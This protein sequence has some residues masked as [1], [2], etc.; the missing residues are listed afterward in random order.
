MMKSIITVTSYILVLSGLQAFP[1][2]PSLLGR[3][4]FNEADGIVCFD[5]STYGNN[6]E[7]VGAER[8]DGIHGSALRFN[9]GNYALTPVNLPTPEKGFSLQLWVKP[10]AEATG[11][12]YLA[13]ESGRFYLRMTENR[14]IVF[15]VTGLDPHQKP[16]ELSAMT[17]TSLPWNEWS[18]VSAVFD[19]T[20]AVAGINGQW[21]GRSSLAATSLHFPAPKPFAPLVLGTCGWDFGYVGFRGSIDEFRLYGRPISEAEALNSYHQFRP[22]SETKLSQETTG[23]SRVLLA[24]EKEFDGHTDTLELA[25]L[26]NF[27]NPENVFMVTGWFRA[28]ETTPG[29]FLFGA[30]NQSFLRFNTAGWLNFGV[31]IDGIGWQEISLSRTVEKN[32]WYHFYCAFDGIRMAMGLDG[33]LDSVLLAPGRL[34]MNRQPIRLG[35][36]AWSNPA[37]AFFTGALRD[38]KIYSYVLDYENLNHA[39]TDRQLRQLLTQAAERKSARVAGEREEFARQQDWARTQLLREPEPERLPQ[40]FTAKQLPPLYGRPVLPD[41]NLDH[42]P[43][44]NASGAVLHGA[45]GETV[46]MSLVFHSGVTVK[47]FLPRISVFRNEAGK[48]LPPELKA[49]KVWYQDSNAGIRIERGF[50]KKLYPE[51]LLYKPDLV[52]V[53]PAG[54][55]NFLSTTDPEHPLVWISE[56]RDRKHDYENIEMDIR[57]VPIRDAATLQPLELV[58]DVNQQYY[59]TVTIPENTAPGG[60]Y[61]GITLMAGDQTIGE[62]PLA[63]LVLP[64]ELSEPTTRYDLTRPFAF[65]VYYWGAL[66]QHAS[67]GRISGHSKNQNQL[68]AELRNMSRYGITAPILI[69]SPADMFQRDFARFDRMMEAYRAAGFPDQKS[70]YFGDSGCIA[71][72]DLERIIADVKALRKHAAEKYGIEEIYF[73]GIDERRGD[74]LLA[75][76]KIWDTVKKQGGAK[77]IVSSFPGQFEAVGDLL[78]L[79][80]WFGTPTR[81]EAAKWHGAGHRIWNY[82]NPQ[83]GV[84]NADINRRNYGLWLWNENYDGNA[85]YCYIDLD[86]QT[87]ND[88]GHTYYRRH[89]FV[90][91]TMDGVINTIQAEGMRGAVTDVRYASTLR[92][93]IARAQTSGTEEEKYIAALAA[94]YLEQL[95]P[96]SPECN[97][98]QIRQTLKEFILKLQANSS[99]Q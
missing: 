59:L 41:S 58:S 83:A 48:E 88:F 51:L 73:Y 5:V 93:E 55:D 69:W 8:V 75:Q 25:G 98:D 34:D 16:V 28:D 10:E 26:E 37:E 31:S 54:E 22:E 89:G 74:E 17:Q 11:D 68:T 56:G 20:E 19:G 24:G 78:D 33:E 85:P 92:K 36:V 57:D 72:R 14:N 4:M 13:G 6:A 32:K 52:Q 84:E 50:D 82:Y 27:F 96:E 49:V 71:G 70:L 23:R 45:P 18:L 15:G 95:H 87:W 90:Y 94:G 29:S 53:D 63:V 61:G 30:G 60:Y 86:G 76:R 12:T 46:Q 42:Y 67:R 64:I 39:D 66:N 35:A 65:S 77:I 2:Q 99:T 7:T 81:S 47:Q 38:V 44:L 43:A 91:P 40:G 1:T 62:L 21:N 97:L 80:V 3:W 9:G 79:C